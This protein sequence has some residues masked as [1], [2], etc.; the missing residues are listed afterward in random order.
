M[1]C[2]LAIATSAAAAHC[3]RALKGC[4]DFGAG[5][6]CSLGRDRC[7]YRHCASRLGQSRRRG[8]THSS[9]S[10]V[11]FRRSAG[12]Q[13]TASRSLALRSANKITFSLCT[14]AIDARQRGC[15]SWQQVSFLPYSLS[16]CP[17]D[18]ILPGGGTHYAFAFHRQGIQRYGWVRI[19]LV[20][21]RFFLASP[22]SWKFATELPRWARP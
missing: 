21:L 18:L 19:S 2:W 7:G 4:V 10:T 6:R 1:L 12:R 17:A 14:F 8:T 22:I 11:S 16:V 13:L 20:M 3:R 9:I 5:L 15:K